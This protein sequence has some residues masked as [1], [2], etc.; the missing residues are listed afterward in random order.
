MGFI[1]ARRGPSEDVE[2]LVVEEDP[3]VIIPDEIA[4]PLVASSFLLLVTAGAGIARH[5]FGL[6]AVS[7]L[8]CITSIVHWRRPRFSS[9]RRPADYFAVLLALGYG[10]LLAATRARNAAWVSIWFGGLAVIGLLFVWNETY[11][12][13]RL[14]RKPTGGEMAVVEDTVARLSMQVPPCCAIVPVAPSNVAERQCVFRRVAWVHLACVH[15]LANA[16]ALLMVLHGL[17]PRV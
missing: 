6:A 11:Y 17:L 5:E 1:V 13:L 12:Y 7:S 8:V 10:S 15:V 9:W 16:L 2:A 3:D 4:R 14:Q